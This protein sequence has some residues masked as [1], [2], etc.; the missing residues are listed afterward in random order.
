M[1][2]IPNRSD[3]LREINDKHAKGKLDF[4]PVQ[5]DDLHPATRAYADMVIPKGVKVKGVHQE[6]NTSVLKLDHPTVKYLLHHGPSGSHMWGDKKFDNIH[7]DTA[8]QILGSFAFK[9]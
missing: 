3:E 2:R 8:P 7:P 6:G 4:K 5:K 1:A 9:D